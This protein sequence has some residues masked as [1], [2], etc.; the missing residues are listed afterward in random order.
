M[1]IGI[2]YV[3]QTGHTQKYAQWLA[4][5]F[6]TEAI[7]F[8]D[9]NKLNIAEC[10]VVIFCSWFHAG[11]LR[12]AN[13][14]QQQIARYSEDK[15]VVLFVGA[16]P[17][18]SEK[19]PA[20]E[21]EEA[22]RKS[23]PESEYPHLAHFYCQGGFDFEKLGILDKIAMRMYFRMLEKEQESD[24][25]Q[26][27]ALKNMRAGFDGTKRAYLQPLIDYIRLREK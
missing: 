20:S 2:L 9:K 6:Q 7:S 11:G 4:E 24:L 14:L 17:M 19:W 5:E 15:F 1:K 22:F 26:A 3:S 8:S 18:P 27:E 16:T 13:W 10:D 23:F 25:R 21:L 12:Q